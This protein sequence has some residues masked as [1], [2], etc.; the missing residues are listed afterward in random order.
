MREVALWSITLGVRA[1]G[2]GIDDAAPAGAR[3]WRHWFWGCHP[4]LGVVT[5][6]NTM[7]PLR[8]LESG[9]NGYVMVPLRG[10]ELVD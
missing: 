9:L 2:M 3:I 4:D 10:Y 6:S 8:G 7:P 5:P 1:A